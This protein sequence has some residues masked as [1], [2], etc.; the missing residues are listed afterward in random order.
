VNLSSASRFK[1]AIGWRNSGQ[2]LATGAL[3]K[4]EL[5]ADEEE[6]K[7]EDGQIESDLDECPG[8]IG[9]QCA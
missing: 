8:S 3:I 7:P 2:S 5:T 1:L 9:I 4:A 6:G